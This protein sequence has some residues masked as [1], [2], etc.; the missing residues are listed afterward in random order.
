MTEESFPIEYS[1]T[2]RSNSV[3]TSRRM[4]RLSASRARRWSRRGVTE[5]FGS[6]GT[7]TMD[8]SPQNKKARGFSRAFDHSRVAGFV[9]LPEQRDRERGDQTGPHTTTGAL[10]GPAAG[11]QHGP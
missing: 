1:M 7:A 6:D 10:A 4:W 2:G 8:I 11:A 5:R 9:C 3:T